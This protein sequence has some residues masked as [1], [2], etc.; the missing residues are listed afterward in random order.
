ML[1]LANKQKDLRAGR[2]LAAPKAKARQLVREVI[3]TAGP[4]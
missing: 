3:V 4:E 2:L 1:I